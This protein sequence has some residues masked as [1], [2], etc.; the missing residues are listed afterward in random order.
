MGCELS[1]TPSL[2]NG[3]SPWDSVDHRAWFGHR[4][5]EPNPL[6]SSTRIWYFRISGKL[7]RLDLKAEGSSFIILNE[8]QSKAIP[9]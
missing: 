8:H 1:P 7:D 9:Y 2:D 3:S 6:P 5:E 4:A